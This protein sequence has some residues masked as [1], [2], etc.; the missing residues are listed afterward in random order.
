MTAVLHRRALAGGAAGA[1]GARGAAR[2]PGARRPGCG[3]RWSRCAGPGSEGYAPID[4]ERRRL[5]ALG[6]RG[7]RARRLAAGRAGAGAAAL[8][9]RPGRGGL[10]DLQP[11][12]ALP[13]RGRALAA[14]SRDRGRRL[15]QRRPLPARLAAGR[16]RLPGRPAGG[17]AGPARRRARPRRRD[18]RRRSRPGGGGCARSG[19]TPSPRR[20]SA[21]GW[22]AATSPACCAASRPGRPSATG[23]PRTP[24]RRP[25]R[26]ASPACWWWRCRPAARSSPSWSQPGFL[27]KLLGL[28]GRGGPAGA[29]RGPAAG[30][31]RRDQAPL[32]GGRVRSAGLAAAVAVLCAFAA[33][34]ELLAA[35]GGAR[36]PALP[37]GLSRR[38]AGAALRLGL[39]ER[40]RRSGLEARLPLAAVLLGQGGRCHRRRPGGAGRGAG[41]AGPDG[42]AGR[43]RAA[44]GRLLRPRRAAR[45]RGAPA[46]AAPGR[47][48]ARRPRPAR[49]QRRLRPRP[50]R[51]ARAAGAGGGG[52]AGRGAADRRRRALLRAAAQRRPA[53]AARPRPRQRAGDP[54]RLDRALAPLRLARSPSSCAARPAPCAATA[55][56]RSRSAPPAPRRRSSSSSP[57][58]SSPRSC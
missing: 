39:P 29:R 14:G 42:P 44:G 34:R 19:S 5:A 41:G 17:R 3:W 18:R 8:G 22:P 7:G 50:R 45:A 49:G 25:R 48:P 40:L 13:G 47:R 6:D 36:L 46:A 31:L 52:P 54:G 28:A 15:A 23:S 24:A 12:P 4:L 53:L 56:A 37:F 51:R 20:C 9:R 32:A 1:G 57:S 21:S 58:S 16:R 10:G 43:A 26:R 38:S 35:R 2:E 11:P 27:A 55:A 30:R 33:G